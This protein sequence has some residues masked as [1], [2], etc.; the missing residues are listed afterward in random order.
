MKNQVASQVKRHF[1]IKV[2][3][4][5]TQVKWH[6]DVTGDVR[7]RNLSDTLKSQLKYRF[8]VLDDYVSLQVKRYF[9]VTVKGTFWRHRGLLMPKMGLASQVTC[10]RDRDQLLGRSIVYFFQMCYLYYRGTHLRLSRCFMFFSTPTLLAVML[11]DTSGQSC[12]QFNIFSDSWVVL[13]SVLPRVQIKS[14]KLRS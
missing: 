1:D 14:H 9:S 6:W 10:R 5:V 13:N 11:L 4:I 7:R 8:D 12:R 2:R 3:S